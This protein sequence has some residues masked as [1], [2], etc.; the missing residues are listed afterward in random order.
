MYFNTTTEVN[1]QLALF[2]HKAADQE[3]VITAYFMNHPFGHTPS[4]VWTG[5]GMEARHVPLTSVRRAITGLT[6]AGVLEKTTMQRPSI[7]NRPEYVWR[8]RRTA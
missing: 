2:R 8:M 4:E 5:T 3:T 6:L 7:Y 1:P